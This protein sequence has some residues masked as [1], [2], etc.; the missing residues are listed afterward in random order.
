MPSKWLSPSKVLE[1]YLIKP[2]DPDVRTDIAEAEKKLYMAVI[3]GEILARWNGRLLGP[4]MLKQIC[5]V[6]E[7]NNSLL[8]P[9]DIELYVHDAERVFGGTVTG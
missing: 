5:H 3:D 7:S 6:A 9:R 4:E 2:K 8:L 1:D